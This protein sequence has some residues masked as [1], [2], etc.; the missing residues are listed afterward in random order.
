MWRRPKS[1]LQET[2][3]W[4]Q[5]L[6]HN[7]WGSNLWPSVFPASAGFQ[8]L[9]NYTKK[10]PGK[11][12]FSHCSL[13]HWKMNI[14][15]NQPAIYSTH[16]QNHRA[17]FL[18]QWIHWIYRVVLASRWDHHSLLSEKIWELAPPFRVTILIHSVEESH[19]PWQI[20]LSLLQLKAE[21]LILP[22]WLIKEKPM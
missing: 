9:R 7:P 8:A 16:Y 21:R 19:R 11:K 6:S 5:E 18:H 10:R 3:I 22:N 1:H 15:D 4:S 2:A 12:H 20:L 17:N 14:A 13:T